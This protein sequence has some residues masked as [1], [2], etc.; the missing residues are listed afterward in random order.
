MFYGLSKFL[1]KI[2][3]KQLFYRS[4]LIVAMPIIILQ[5]TISVVFFDS[6]WIKTNIGMT[7]AL[8]GEIKTFIDSYN[9]EGSEKNFVENTFEEYLNID[10]I[11]FQN[12]EFSV[13]MDEKWYSPIDRALRRELKSKNLK[14]WFDTSKFKNTVNLKIKN[15]QDYFEF[16]IPR[17]RL[18]STSV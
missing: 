12:K 8:V 4:L 14:Y 11:Y 1:K 17:E 9:R 3:P 16:F 15:G 7:R 6:L 2:L 5:I 10:V 18:T 13:S